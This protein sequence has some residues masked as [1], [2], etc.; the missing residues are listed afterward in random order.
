MTRREVLGLGAMSAALAAGGVLLTDKEEDREQPQ[1]LGRSIISDLPLDQ[2]LAMNAEETEKIWKMGAQ[3]YMA[4]LRRRGHRLLAEKNPRRQKHECVDERLEDGVTNC[5]AGLGVHIPEQRSSIAAHMIQDALAEYRSLRAQGID[6][7]IVIDLTWHG[8]GNCGAALLACKNG[9]PANPNRIFTREE[10][11]TKAEE[12]GTLLKAEIERQLQVLGMSHACIVNV[13][14]VPPSTVLQADGHPGG[15]VLIDGDE[16]LEFNRVGEPLLAYGAS[17]N[18]FRQKSVKDAVLSAKIMMG[19]HGRA[20]VYGKNHD[21]HD[22]HPDLKETDKPLFVL[23]GP[24]DVRRV[25]RH[26]LIT[27]LQ[28]LPEVDQDRLVGRIDDWDTRPQ[29]L[30]RSA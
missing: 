3:A 16:D 7:P 22:P 15:V 21:A 6:E 20:H 25:M 4:D 28:Q 10:I 30:R 27:E 9:D 5:L 19:K 24:E 2:R 17:Y 12:G 13:G 8:E 18:R 23:A 29:R 26:Q 1:E 14:Q 11:D